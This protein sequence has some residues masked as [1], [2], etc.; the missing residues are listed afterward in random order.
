MAA[1]E[2]L[3]L[4]LREEERASVAVTMTVA[5]EMVEGRGGR[6]VVDDVDVVVPIHVAERKI[7]PCC[8]P[9]KEEEE[10]R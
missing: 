3:L 5:L 6:V 8:H 10:E 9:R 2:L 7:E 1:A 4:L